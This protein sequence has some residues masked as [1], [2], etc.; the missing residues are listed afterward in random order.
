[1]K[2]MR[3][4][5]MYK[6]IVAIAV[7]L[8]F[9][10][11][12]SAA[13]ANVG[14]FGVTPNSE[15]TSDMENMVESTNSGITETTIISDNSDNSDA[16]DTDLSTTLPTLG[17]IE[18]DDDADPNWYDETHVRTIQEGIDN[19]TAEDMV[20]VFD[21]IYYEHV[22]VNKQLDLVGESRENVIVDGSGSGMVIKITV[23]SVNISTFAMT[24]GK[25]GIYLESSSNCNIIN[26]DVYNNGE[27]N[28]FYNYAYGIYLNDSSYNNIENC[29]CYNNGGSGFFAY[30]YGIYIHG[31]IGTSKNNQIINC[32]AYSNEGHGDLISC[33]YGIYLGDYCSGTQV[34]DCNASNN[35]D[36]GIYLTGSSD[37]NITNCNASYNA[38]RGICLFSSSNKHITNC[39]AYGNQYG[40]Y[41]YS[42]S[43]CELIGNTIYDNIYNFGIEGTDIVHFY[44]NIEASNTVDGEPIYYI[45][46]QSN[47][48]FNG[49]GTFYGTP[50]FGYLGLISCTNI[51][52]KNLD[53]W[54]IVMVNTTD[55]TISNVNSYS[56]KYG[57]Y[58]YY[59]SNNDIINCNAYNNSKDG[60]YFYTSSN[61][62]IINC[63]AYNNAAGFYIEEG[64]SD[65][66]IVECDIYNN[67]ADGIFFLSSSNNDIINCNAYY[68][69]RDGFSIWLSP[70]SNVMGCSAYNNSKKGVL[71]ESSSNSDITDCNSYNNSKYGIHLSSSSNC[72]ITNCNVY[73]NSQY[74][75]YIAPNS[76]NNLLYHN[77]FVNN[78][79]NAYD[80]CSNTWDDGYPSGGNYWDDYTGDDLFQGPDQNIP[81]S[82]GIG[83]IPYNIPGGSNQDNFPLMSLWDETP[84]AI[85]NVQAIPSA[86]KPNEPLNITCTVTDNLGLVDTVKINITGPAGF[87]LEATMNEGSYYYEDTYTTM[88]VYHY[89][90]WANDTN[91]NNATSSVYHFEIIE[92]GFIEITTLSYKW[93][94]IAV[95]FD[96]SVDKADII[97]E[98]DGTD[99]TWA[100][101]VSGG[102][103]ADAL[104]GW[105][106]I[107]QMYLVSDVLEPG[108][109]YWLWAYNDCILKVLE[110]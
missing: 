87:A 110:P 108:C 31:G 57:I 99:Y 12:T 36:D 67:K 100:D 34:T 50:I 46:E 92:L 35:K 69:G 15:N 102:I 73:N 89:F 81:G 56:G 44:H 42:S 52:V 91:G 4:K 55:S 3:K 77:N 88:G 40:I 109:G 97:V 19:A 98:Y 43:N 61:N 76:D 85:T 39:N 18:V 1:M 14:T 103:I 105:D 7:A 27:I 37:N 79:Q 26:C 64:S 94:M 17:T 90:I 5:N 16:K 84:P 11:P 58:S 65:N 96:Y 49:T 62:D 48:T 38:Q 9:I 75:I 28:G 51:T 78:V 80:E 24:N 107:S 6:A 86:Q 32:N 66:N 33:G 82:D 74:G 20:Y 83:D 8:A 13:F 104:F 30:G 22:T 59:S 29:D 54:G 53:V 60:I 106:R 93:N 70:K 23:D 45:V 2:E 71:L 68:N 41:F 63:N 72:N 25:Y 47:L 21:G 10:L 101:A 95:P